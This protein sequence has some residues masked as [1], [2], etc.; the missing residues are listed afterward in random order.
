MEEHHDHARYPGR[1]WPHAFAF[2]IYLHV[3]AVLAFA[4]AIATGIAAVSPVTR[5]P[6]FG[7]PRPGRTPLLTTDAR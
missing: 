2:F 3:A 6:K 5:R 1:F 7:Y 4:S